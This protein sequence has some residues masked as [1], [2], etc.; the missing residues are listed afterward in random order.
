MR[1][2]SLAC[3]NTE[4]VCALGC[5]EM[6]VGVDDHSDHPPEVV[7][8]LPRV[9]PDLGVDPARVAALSPDLVLASLT[10]PGH[11]RVVESLEAVGLPLL[12]LAPKRLDDV[13]HDVRRI[14][15]ALGVPARG[16]ALAAELER[17]LAPLPPIGE[18]P[19]RILVE[20]WPRP[21]IAPGKKSWVTDLIERAGGVNPLAGDDVESRPLTDE[22]AAAL[23]PDA[24]VLSWCGVPFEKY[25]PDV[26]RR[27]E[28]F[29][30]TPALVHDRVCCISEAHLG[31]PGP[32]LVDGLRELREVVRACVENSA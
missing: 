30:K 8:A 12:V 2:V 20:W 23:A 19:P 22:E 13:F 4:I 21:V 17:G 6:L 16:E 15:E 11:E 18:R 24:V 28:A 3:S 10:V 9:G 26:V 14:A 7:R 29:A 31:R 25:R 5:A 27:R 32:R 1:V